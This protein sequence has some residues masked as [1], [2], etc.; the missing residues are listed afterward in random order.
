MGN[1]P[2][3]NYITLAIREGKSELL[4]CLIEE[5]IDPNCRSLEGKCGDS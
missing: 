2:K 5:E 1:Y 3:G 4:E